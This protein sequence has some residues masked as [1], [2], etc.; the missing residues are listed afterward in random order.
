MSMNHRN[1]YCENCDKWLDSPKDY[2]VKQI[3][4]SDDVGGTLEYKCKTCD[5]RAIVEWMITGNEFAC[6][7]CYEILSKVDEETWKN[8]KPNYKKRVK[9]NHGEKEDGRV[10][11]KH[12]CW[13]KCSDCNEKYQIT[14][15]YVDNGNIYPAYNCIPC[16]IKNL[17][18]EIAEGSNIQQNKEELRKLEKLV[19]DS[20]ERERERAKLLNYE[21]RY[22]N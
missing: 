13:K 14:Q 17:K 7:W 6:G 9:I 15:E 11:I 3:G 19:G 1:P 18:K 22:S 16:A 12:D 8:A 2:E 10:L 5:N 20:R 4:R 21:L